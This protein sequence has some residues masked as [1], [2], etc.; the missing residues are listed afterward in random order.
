MT[1]GQ[2]MRRAATN[3]RP[4]RPRGDAVCTH[5]VLHITSNPPVVLYAYLSL[6]DYICAHGV[7]RTTLC[8]PFSAFFSI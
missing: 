2:G 5:T 7:N 3:T 4:R 8:P 6:D 1:N